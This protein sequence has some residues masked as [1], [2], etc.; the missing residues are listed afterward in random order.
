[1]IA[2]RITV[3]GNEGS[4]VTKID[5]SPFQDRRSPICGSADPEQ[6]WEPGRNIMTARLTVQ[7]GRKNWLKNRPPFDGDALRLKP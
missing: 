5:F 2:L 4:T 7:D 6:S 1:M 3:D